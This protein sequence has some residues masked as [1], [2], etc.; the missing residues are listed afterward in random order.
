MSFFIG[1][2]ASFTNES[3]GVLEGVGE[4]GAL[5]GATGLLPLWVVNALRLVRAVRAARHYDREE[6]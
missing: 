5:K 3:L 1:Y 6:M 4:K 2:L